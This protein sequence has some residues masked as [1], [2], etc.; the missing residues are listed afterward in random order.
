MLKGQKQRAWHDVVTLD[1]SWFYWSADN[2]SIG[3]PPGEKVLEIPRASHFNAE[4]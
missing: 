2:K 4:N 3:L 1:K